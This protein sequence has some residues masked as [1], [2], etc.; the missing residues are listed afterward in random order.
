MLGRGVACIPQRE[1]GL[2]KLALGS[3]RMIDSQIANSQG[4]A[5]LYSVLAIGYRLSAMQSEPKA[6]FARQFAQAGLC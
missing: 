2:A 1:A 3:L 4:A 5:W 6:S